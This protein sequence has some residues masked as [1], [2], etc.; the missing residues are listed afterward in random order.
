ML[1]YYLEWKENAGKSGIYNYELGVDSV[2]DSASPSILPF[3]STGHHPSFRLPSN[4]LPVNSEFYFF[5]KTITK[6]N[7][8]NIQVIYIF[9]L[10]L[11]SL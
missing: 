8:E 4:V 2:P 10:L 5:I 11:I 9:H 7:K 6:A 3:S 1:Q